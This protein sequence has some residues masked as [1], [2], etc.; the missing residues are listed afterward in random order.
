MSSILLQLADRTPTR[1]DGHFGRESKPGKGVDLGVTQGA[2][3]HSLAPPSKSLSWRIREK[4]GVARPAGGELPEP[5]P[6][7]ALSRGIL[8]QSPGDLRM[9]TICKRM[10]RFALPSV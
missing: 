4:G 3:R 6:R 10:V 8:L 7:H 1:L 2:F 9:R 5:G